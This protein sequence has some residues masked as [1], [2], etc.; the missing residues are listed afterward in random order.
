MTR[1]EHVDVRPLRESD[2]PEA[3]RIFRLAFGTFL[4]LP[5]PMAFGGDRDLVG[6][7]WRI[8]PAAALGAYRGGELVGSNFVTVWGSVGFFGPLTVRPDLWDRGVARSLLDATVALLD[9]RGVRHG[10]LY[11][12]AESPRHT[13]LYQKYGFWPRFLNVTFRLEAVPGVFSC[14][15]DEA[16]GEFRAITDVI[17]EGFDLTREV[18]AVRVLGAGDTV[19]ADGA[20]AVCHVGPGTEGGRGTCYVKCAAVRPGAGAGER[21]EALLDACLGFAHA[22]GAEVVV[23]GVDTGRT[24]AYRRLLARGGRVTQQG[25][26]MHRPGEP[27][28]DRPDVHALD[29]WR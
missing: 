23:A 15:S 21:F 1:L 12:F 17:Y 13:T 24:D 26:A 11:T 2:L 20:F 9:A 29:D 6:G 5:D 28:Y 18:E 25:I 27:G 4:E 3:D 16:P 22:R 7:R 14:R 19:V 8:D 10:G